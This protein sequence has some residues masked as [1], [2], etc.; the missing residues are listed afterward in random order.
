MQTP[1][2]FSWNLN[3]PNEA[4]SIVSAEITFNSLDG[5]PNETV[6]IG[7]NDLVE[8]DRPVGILPGWNNDP[9]TIPIAEGLYDVIFT[10][11]DSAGNVGN[12][13]ISSFT[14]DTLETFSCYYIQSFV[15]RRW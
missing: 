4:T 1:S 14:Y 13:T 8:G 3:E 15:C 2:S 12:D 9:Y 5:N 11:L 10:S 6:T 7:A